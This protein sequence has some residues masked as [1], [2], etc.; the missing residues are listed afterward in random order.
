MSRVIFMALA[1]MIGTIDIVAAQ[2]LDVKEWPVEWQGRPRDPDVDRQG[3]V[4]FVGQ[5]GNYIGV[6]DP[7]TEQF[8][9]HELEERTLPH[10]LIVGADG[11]IWYAGNG[12]G[13]IGRLDPETGEARIFMMPDEAARD[14][15][16][17]IAD[18]DGS[19]IWFTVQQGGYIGRLNRESG[20]V[21]LIATGER[22]RPY[23]IVVDSKGTVWANLFG[24]NKLAAIDP[25]TLQLREIETPRADARTRRLVV[26]SDDRVWYVDFAGGK[27]GRLDPASGAIRE[28]DLPGGARSQPYAMAVD[29]QDRIW[30][31]ESNRDAPRLVGFDP[32]TEQ[33]MLSTP[34]SAGIRHMVYHPATNTIW[35]GT[36][37]NNIGRAVLP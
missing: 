9:R 20:K 35:F 18:A 22:T 25:A 33:F 3:R 19:N 34:V 4:W 31:A 11:G 36:D 32:A 29:S 27:L 5:T 15:H 21:D 8:R 12:N 6:F 10:N 7:A 14:P 30:L 13:R 24:T 23:G 2:T 17:L 26:T 37:A 1:T 28:W 16:T